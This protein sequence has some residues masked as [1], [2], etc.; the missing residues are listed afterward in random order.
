MY[1]T[2]IVLFKCYNKLSFFYSLTALVGL[3][4]L[5]SRTYTV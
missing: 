1:V 4:L 3:R 5:K 2:K